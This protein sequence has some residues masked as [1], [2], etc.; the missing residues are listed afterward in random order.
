MSDAVRKLEPQT[1]W[2][3]FADLNSVPRPSKKEERVRQFMVDFGNDIPKI[4]DNVLMIGKDGSNEIRFETISNT[5][6]STPYVL[7]T[8][9]GG[10]TQ[11]IYQG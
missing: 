11:R 4:D 3:H 2:N 6:K 8:G 1:V 10:R 5:I 7:A 9:I